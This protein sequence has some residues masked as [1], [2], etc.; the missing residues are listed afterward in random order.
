[1]SG[2]ESSCLPSPSSC[3]KSTSSTTAASSLV[4]HLLSD[5]SELRQQVN[6]PEVLC[7]LALGKNAATTLTSWHLM[8]TLLTLHVT[9]RLR[10]F[11]PKPIDPRIVG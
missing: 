5:F 1:M 10:F 8:V 9:Q 11:E 3:E 4:K 6:I 7:G 2:E